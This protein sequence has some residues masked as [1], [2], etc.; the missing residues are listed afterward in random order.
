MPLV[1]LLQQRRRPE[2]AVA[3]QDDPGLLRQ[4][5]PHIVQQRHLLEGTAMTLAAV[6]PGPGDRQ[7]PFAIG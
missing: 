2:L 6:H 7:G 3:H 5:L 1:Q 4:E